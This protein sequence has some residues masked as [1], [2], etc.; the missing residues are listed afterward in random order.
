MVQPVRAGDLF[1]NGVATDAARLGAIGRLFSEAGFASRVFG[2]SVASTRAAGDAV[3][4]AG[5]LAVPHRF[6]AQNFASVAKGEHRKS[7]TRSWQPLV[8]YTAY[9]R[10]AS[11]MTNFMRQCVP[12][13]LR[14][15]AY[16]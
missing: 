14:T 1:P 7:L 13:R 5:R 16:S 12:S 2:V 3:S 10:Y 11:S 8:S 15:V 4:S 9:S 6:P